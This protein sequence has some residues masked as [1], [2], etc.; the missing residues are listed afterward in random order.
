MA[1]EKKPSSVPRDAGKPLALGQA[2]GGPA[3]EFLLYRSEDGHT[4]VE[5]RFVDE[6]LWSGRRRLDMD[7][8]QVYTPGVRWLGR[9]AGAPSC[10]RQT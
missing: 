9:R 5:C 2:A 4:R 7:L 6:S 1:S 3:G 10:E 8:P